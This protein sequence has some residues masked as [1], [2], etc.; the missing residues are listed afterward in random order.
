MLKI[1][2]QIV[3]ITGFFPYLQGG[4]EL[5]SY[6]LAKRCLPELEVSFVFRDHWGKGSSKD[7]NGYN[8]HPIRPVKLIGLGGSF[9]FET[10]QL[11]NILTQV[12]PRY[13]YVRGANA[14]LGIATRYAKHNY[15]KIVWHIAS[16]S[17]V[18]PFSASPLRAIVSDYIDRKAIEYGIKNVDSI[19]AQTQFQANRLLLNYS[20]QA[21]VISN[22]HPIPEDCVKTDTPVTVLWVANWKPIKQPE[23]FVELARTLATEKNIRFVMIGRN[24]RYSDLVELA[25]TNN[26][27]V[28]GEVSSDRANDLLA[29]SHILVNT[30]LYEGFSN[31]FI[32]AWMRRVPVVSL[33]VDPD[34]IIRNGQIGFCSSGNFRELVQ[35]TGVLIR[36]SKLRNT[37]GARARKYAIKHHSLEN[38][39]EILKT[40]M[41]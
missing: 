5:Q 6:L 40:I 23:F 30:S 29:Q 31:T 32:Q 36:D 8:L 7:K 13:I 41:Q 28:I 19:I 34:N 22:G 26:I 27:E 10:R 18:I 37:M 20:R 9:I 35:N 33:R 21:A 14:Y 4:A 1:K 15:T 2:E 24:D 12:K 38:I 3:F 16:D 39:D 11:Y 25:K 17:D